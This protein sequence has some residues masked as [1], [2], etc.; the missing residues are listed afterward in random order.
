MWPYRHDW[1]W[2]YDTAGG[3]EIEQGA[4]LWEDW[5]ING[6]HTNRGLCKYHWTSIHDSLQNGLLQLF[7]RIFGVPYD[8]VLPAFDM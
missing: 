6:P 3:M 1:K 4:M 2:R 5:T 7:G 8:C